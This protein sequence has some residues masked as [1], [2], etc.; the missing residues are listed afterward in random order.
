MASKN[1]KLTLPYGMG[2]VG[3]RK[4]MREKLIIREESSWDLQKFE[5]KREIKKEEEIE[6]KGR[7]VVTW[8]MGDRWR[9]LEGVST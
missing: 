6:N 4:R 2:K 1:F 8:E 3:N 7:G 9:E 5:R